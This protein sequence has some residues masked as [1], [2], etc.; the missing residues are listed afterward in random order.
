M[1]IV[2]A[3]LPPFYSNYPATAVPAMDKSAT[4][5]IKTETIMRQVRRDASIKKAALGVQPPAVDPA[6]MP[7]TGNVSPPNFSHLPKGT[8]DIAPPM[9]H[10]ARELLELHDREFIISAYRIILNREPDSEG[11]TYYLQAIR[12]GKLSKI[13]VLGRLR[14]SAEGRSEG[15]KICGLMAR[16][17]FKL[18]TKLPIVGYAIEVITVLFRLPAMARRIDQLDATLHAEDNKLRDQVDAQIL[19]QNEVVQDLAKIMEDV[20]RP[21]GSG[22][23]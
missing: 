20:S 11:A 22:Q 9:R 8:N 10:S 2:K 21:K 15:T 17:G 1:E 18:L 23:S 13:E 5:D 12:S 4:N 16:F 3:C 6:K 14:Y 7:L 19:A